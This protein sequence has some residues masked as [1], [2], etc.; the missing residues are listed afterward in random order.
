MD[1]IIEAALIIAFVAVVIGL[2]VPIFTLITTEVA[3]AVT[4]LTSTI[5]VLSPYFDFARGMLYQFV[6]SVTIANMFVIFAVLLPLMYFL[7]SVTARVINMFV[8]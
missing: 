6:G 2:C 1:V 4:L 3:S 7:I 5:G 8:K